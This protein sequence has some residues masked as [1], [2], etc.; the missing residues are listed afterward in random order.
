[1]S[2]TTTQALPVLPLTA[3]VV[4]PG[5]G[6]HHP[7]STRPR[8]RPRRRRLEHAGGRLLL[9]P[10]VDGRYATRRHH[11]RASRTPAA[12]PSSSAASSA[13]SWARRPTGRRRHAS[14]S[15]PSP[16]PR[17]RR[18]TDEARA[19]AR[20][21]RAI[22]EQ[23][24]DLRG[25]GRLTGGRAR[26]ARAVAGRRPGAAG[27]P[28]CRSR[29]RSRSSRPS[30]SRSGCACAPLGRKESL[31]ELER[32]RPR[33]TARSRDGIDKQQREALL[34]RRMEAIRSELGD[35]DDGDDA[36]DYRARLD[37]SG[38]A[39]GRA[40][41]VAQELDRLERMSA[42][43]PEHGWIVT[44]LDTVL[45]SRGHRTPTSPSTLDAVRGVLDADHAGLDDV[46]DRI[47]EY[48][49]VR[50]LRAERGI[51]ATAPVAGAGRDPRPRRP[52]RRRQDVARRVGRPRARPA[53][54]ARRRSA[55]CATRPRS[56]ATAAPTSARSPVA[57]CGPSPR[58][59]P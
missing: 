1:M 49:A 38:A 17:P 7:A 30:T 58:P 3:G 14:G 56:A 20:E 42:Q 25:A 33:S 34:R 37:S 44:W 51:E 32:H 50:K 45:D 26:H 4:A 28:T 35:D 23:I 16:S 13:P 31:A 27:R 41:R 47:M 48:L 59:A 9:V 36:D 19:L 6:R 52:A 54:R 57:S 21:Y 15:P 24:L 40:A 2:D 29:R 5:H 53:V 39:R 8:R 22:V 55:A 12:A 18:P 10:H 43:S 46:K 11:R